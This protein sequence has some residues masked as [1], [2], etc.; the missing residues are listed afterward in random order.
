MSEI[1]SVQLFNIL[2]EESLVKDLFSRSGR[3]VSDAFIYLIDIKEDD[4]IT[5]CLQKLLQEIVLPTE[6]QKIDTLAGSY[7]KRL[8]ELKRFP[9]ESVN[10]LCVLLYSMIMLK[11]NLQDTE[12]IKKMTVNDFIRSNLKINDG[13]DFPK[14][15]IIEI[16]NEI[17]ELYYTEP[18]SSI[19]NYA[20][21]HTQKCCIM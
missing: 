8:F 20:F 12:S 18:H 11:Q 3:R 10:G 16:Y 7:A 5:K 2:T 1:A 9:S 21:E 17:K 6:P 15:F 14:E 4:T 19:Q 13:N